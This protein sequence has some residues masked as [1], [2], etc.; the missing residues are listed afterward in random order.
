MKVL[1]LL[2][3][4]MNKI[5][6]RKKGKLKVLKVLLKKQILKKLKLK[7][8]QQKKKRKNL[9]RKSVLGML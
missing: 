2:K 7:L 1:K 4:K 3:E 9:S 6:W 8:I 5:R